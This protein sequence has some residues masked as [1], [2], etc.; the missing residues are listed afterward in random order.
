[1]STTYTE[2]RT[3]GGWCLIAIQGTLDAPGTMEI[4]EALQALLT[5]Y[6][7][8]VI[9]DLSGVTIMSSYGLRMLLVIAKALHAGG[10]ELHLAGANR[11]VMEIITLSGCDTVFPVYRTV[12]DAVRALG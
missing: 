6:G 4:E 2:Q 12:A 11:S 7:E 9:V 10:G 8:P 3:E 1:M 5:G